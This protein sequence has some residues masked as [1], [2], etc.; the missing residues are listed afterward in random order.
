MQIFYGKNLE[1]VIISEQLTNSH[2]KIKNEN[3]LCFTFTFLLSSVP[4]CV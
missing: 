3:R 2:K 4:P 1:L